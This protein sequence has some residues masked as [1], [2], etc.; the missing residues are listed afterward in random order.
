MPIEKN[1]SVEVTKEEIPLD[2]KF[3][4][5]VLDMVKQV[6]LEGKL[7]D[8]LLKSLGEDFTYPSYDESSAEVKEMHPKAEHIIEAVGESG[9][10]PFLASLVLGMGHVESWDIEKM[11]DAEVQEKINPLMEE[12]SMERMMLQ[13]MHMFNYELQGTIAHAQ[14]AISS[15]EEDEESETDSS[16]GELFHALMGWS[17]ATDNSIRK[18]I[19]RQAKGIDYSK[20]LRD[21]MRSLLTINQATEI[22]P[23]EAWS[24]LDLATRGRKG[25]NEFFKDADGDSDDFKAMARKNSNDRMFG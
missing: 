24:Y 8:K 21:S 15:M 11:T 22:T 6:N 4:S 19:N 18:A 5:K 3:F 2:Q 14:K 1:V 9:V 17:I 13:F 20:R 7:V 12:K 16:E 10:T 25:L 23:Y